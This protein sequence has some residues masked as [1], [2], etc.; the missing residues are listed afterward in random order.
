[1]SLVSLIVIIAV[2]GL[3]VWLI[4]AY[5]PMPQPFKTAILIVALLVVVLLIL[6]AF[7][8]LDDLRGVRV[9]HV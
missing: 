8:I 2:I 5:V 7:G 9:P 3:F 6:S 4:T 1:M